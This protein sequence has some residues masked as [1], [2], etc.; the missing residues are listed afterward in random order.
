MAE[1]LYVAVVIGYGPY[2][3]MVPDFSLMASGDTQDDVLT[4]LQ[5]LTDESVALSQQYG[6]EIPKATAADVI[7]SHWVGDQYHFSGV[8]VRV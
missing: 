6:T 5:K 7:K 1:T 4:Q 3:G 8:V 2:Y